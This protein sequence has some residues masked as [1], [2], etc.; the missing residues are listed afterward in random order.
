MTP[1]SPAGDLYLV[2][3]SR[4]LLKRWSTSSSQVRCIPSLVRCTPSSQLVRCIPSSQLVRCIPSSQLVR[5][6]PSSQLVRCIPS[7]QLIRCIP[8]SQLVRCIPSSQ[9]VRCIP[10]SQ[11]DLPGTLH[12]ELKAWPM[13]PWSIDYKS[14]L[15]ADWTIL[16]PSP[17]LKP[18]HAFPC[19]TAGSH[20][21]WASK[22]GHKY[23]LFISPCHSRLRSQSWLHLLIHDST[24]GGHDPRK[25]M[26]QHKNVIC[27]V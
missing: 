19:E 23:Q 17:Q 26:Y 20:L 9:L 11:H 21:S 18:Y 6:I 5:C 1:W 16:T 25:Q 12:S 10:S 3:W 14:G 15:F 4:T 7:S 22:P 13:N 8:S 2:I 24:A 27:C